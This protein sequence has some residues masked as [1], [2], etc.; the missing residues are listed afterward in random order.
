[1]THHAAHCPVC[2]SACRLAPFWR[3]VVLGWLAGLMLTTR[4]AGWWTRRTT[5]GR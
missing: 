3:G 1:M 4:R 2:R 5:G